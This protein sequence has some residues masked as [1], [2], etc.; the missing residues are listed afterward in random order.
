M[1]TR[2]GSSWSLASRILLLQAVVLLVVVGS[3]LVALLWETDSDTERVASMQKFPGY[4][5]F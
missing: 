2:V 1:R 5:P 4:F 3:A